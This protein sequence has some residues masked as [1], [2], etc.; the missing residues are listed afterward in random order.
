MP[1]YKAEYVKDDQPDHEIVDL[2]AQA[3]EDAYF[4]GFR[5]VDKKYDGIDVLSFHIHKIEDHKD[6]HD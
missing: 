5:L 4:E 3:I 2:Q 6:G 1:K